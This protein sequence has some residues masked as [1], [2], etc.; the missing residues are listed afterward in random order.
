MALREIIVAGV[1]AGVL[2][3]CWCN[4]GAFRLYVV[5]RLTCWCVEGV[6]VVDSSSGQVFRVSVSSALTERSYP[7]LPGEVVSE[8][9]PRGLGPLLPT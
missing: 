9:T 7:P 1:L 8:A 6:L 4:L 5:I 2:E 3:E